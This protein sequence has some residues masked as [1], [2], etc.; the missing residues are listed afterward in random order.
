M[1]K[2]ICYDTIVLSRKSEDATINDLS[3]AEDL[4]DTLLSKKEE[5]VGMAA[6]MIGI[7]KRIIC[8]YDGDIIK[9]MF[10]PEIVKFSGLY[11]EKE[12]CLSHPGQIKSTKRYQK[13]HVKYYN[14][15]F[16]IKRETYEGFVAE[17][18]QHEIDHCNGI[19]I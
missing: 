5:C 19:L 3:I 14:N 1:I 10:N 11:F 18:I 13:I 6:N 4:K 2:N 7:N 15:E 8:F 12:G 9:T 16:H 17:I